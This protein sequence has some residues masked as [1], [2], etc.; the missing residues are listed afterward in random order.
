V[1]R[2]P[3]AR[4]RTFHACLS[5]ISERLR[6]LHNII[7][8]VMHRNHYHAYHAD[9]T[10]KLARSGISKCVRLLL[11]KRVA[12]ARHRLPHVALIVPL[13]F[14]AS[15]FLNVERSF[16]RSSLVSP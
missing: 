1:S 3:I 8:N 6:I 13:N 10:R 12:I 14:P 4:N 7:I 15:H 2:V 16:D 5:R 9:L 11:C